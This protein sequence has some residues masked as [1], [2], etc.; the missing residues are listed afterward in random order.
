MKVHSEIGGKIVE[1]VLQGVED[2]KFVQIAKNIAHY[3]HERWDGNG[4]PEKLKGEE[5]PLEARIMAFV[6]VYDALISRRCYKERMDYEEAFH[7][8]EQSMGTHFDPEIGKVF[9]RCRK[10][11]EAYYKSTENA[12]LDCMG[13]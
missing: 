4:Y 6:D 13:R 12:M 7:I 11:F 1:T 8:M 2:Q 3:H 10:K 9:L 5:I